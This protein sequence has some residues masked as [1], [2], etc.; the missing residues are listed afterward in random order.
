MAASSLMTSMRTPTGRPLIPR[1]PVGAQ[2][3][4]LGPWQMDRLVAGNMMDPGIGRVRVSR[5][6]YD[7]RP[8][9]MARLMTLHRL[10]TF[11]PTWRQYRAPV[12]VAVR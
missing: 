10:H 8:D 12:A 7:E 9:R 4:V 5:D 6:W 3:P 11:L 2:Q 1:W